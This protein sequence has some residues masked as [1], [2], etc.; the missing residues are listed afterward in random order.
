MPKFSDI[1]KGTRARRTIEFPADNTRCK[2][3]VPLPELADQQARD[4][5][6]WEKERAAQPGQAAPI[7]PGATV[8]VD[9]RVLSGEEEAV[10]LDKARKFAIGRGV[11]VPRDGEPIYDLAV[12][13]ETLA[14]ACVDSESPEEAPALFFE[15]SREILDG[16]DRERIVYVYTVWETWQEECSPQAKTMPPE[17]FFDIVVRAADSEDPT[18]PFCRLRPGMQ[19]IC[20]RTMASLLISLLPLKSLRS[21]LSE[22][23]TTSGGTP[24]TSVGD[25]TGPGSPPD[26]THPPASG[27]AG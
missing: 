7:A 18:D 13:I 1:Q 8:K 24:T 6:R 20:F 3:L 12:M 11:K 10:V 2:L 16:M 23:G 21:S 22:L 15:S 17:E 26:P 25:S 19:W 5:E 14:L 4:Q 27:D 9:L